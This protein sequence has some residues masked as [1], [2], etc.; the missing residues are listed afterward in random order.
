MTYH[1]PTN[2]GAA[3]MAAGHSLIPGKVQQASGSGAWV[4]NTGGP[5]GN[6]DL[7]CS[8]GPLN[9]ILA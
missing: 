5:S 2:A 6:F 1:L 7:D 8:F 9:M 3:P 4:E